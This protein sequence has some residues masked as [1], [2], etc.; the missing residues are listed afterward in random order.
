MKK[1]LISFILILSALT[2]SAQVKVLGKIEPNGPTDTYPTHVD[3]LGKGGLIAVGSWQE[4]NAIPLAR[5]K[6]GML[7]RVK[8]AMI[9]STYTL[10]IGR[11]NDNWT[12]YASSMDLNGKANLS[13]GNSFIGTQSM[14][15]LL[16]DTISFDANNPLYFGRSVGS[17]GPQK[18]FRWTQGISGV[19]Q[20]ILSLEAAHNNT[21]QEAMAIYGNGLEVRIR[22]RLTINN[23]TNE[24]RTSIQS[25]NKNTFSNTITLPSISDTLATISDLND[26]ASLTKV[27]TFLNTQY[28]E[29]DLILTGNVETIGQLQAQAFVLYD[30]FAGSASVIFNVDP[31]AVQNTQIDLTTPTQSG[32]LALLAD[33]PKMFTYTTSGDNSSL[34]F[35]IPHGLSYIPTMVIVTANSVDAMGQR[36]GH[37]RAEISG[38]NVIIHY[39]DAPYT[40]TNNL[41]WTI[42]VK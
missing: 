2:V 24:Y 9:D 18:E 4:R 35:T 8:S 29:G 25:N 3:S 6:A 38:S 40:G 15:K 27:N 10:N 41:K 17:S 34:E 37:Y 12:P 23:G 39:Q 20:G 11:T 36:G 30:P 33:I 1:I 14:P 21:W 22:N 31:Q 28:L 32:K 26:K 13:G 5:R 42:M 7:V 19:N 16:A